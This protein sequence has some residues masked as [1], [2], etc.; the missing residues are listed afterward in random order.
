MSNDNICGFILRIIFL[1]M[2]KQ[3]L[4]K[5]SIEV[6]S[7]LIEKNHF[8]SMNTSTD[9]IYSFTLTDRKVDNGI[10]FEILKLKIRK[11]ILVILLIDTNIRKMLQKKYILTNGKLLEKWPVNKT[12]SEILLPWRK[13]IFSLNITRSWCENVSNKRK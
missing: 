3:F 13:N 10:V 5:M 8:R 2:L 4:E 7:W 9:D 1:D 11:K 12:V 6:R